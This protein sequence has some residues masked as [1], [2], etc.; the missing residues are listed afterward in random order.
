MNAPDPI[1]ERFWTT[2]ACI[3]AQSPERGWYT[4][5]VLKTRFVDAHPNASPDEYDAAMARIARLAGV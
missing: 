4:Y 1:K 5:E 3:A 2:M